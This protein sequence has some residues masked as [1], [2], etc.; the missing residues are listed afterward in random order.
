MNPLRRI[1]GGFRRFFGADIFISHSHEDAAEYAVA[2]AGRL[3]KRLAVYVDRYDSQPGK[4]ISERVVGH[5][6]SAS[7][8]VVIASPRSAA[9]PPVAEEVRRFAKLKRNILVVDIDGALGQCPW[10]DDVQGLSRPTDTEERRKAGRPDRT[11]VHSILASFR[12]VTRAQRLWRSAFAAMALVIV[13][14]IATVFFLREARRQQAIA[15]AQRIATTA[16]QAWTNQDAPLDSTLLL[17]A[18]SLRL[19]P[20]AEARRIVIEALPLRPSLQ[21]EADAALVPEATPIIHLSPDGRWVVG[22][23]GVLRRTSDGRRMWSGMVTGDPVFAPDGSAMAFWSSGEEAAAVEMVDLPQGSR[24]EWPYPDSPFMGLFV[25]ASDRYVR[26]ESS[27]ANV[28]LTEIRRRSDNALLASL[29][30][31]GAAAGTHKVALRVGNGTVE[32]RDLRDPEREGP[33]IELPGFIGELHVSADDRL[34][35]LG[36]WVGGMASSARGGLIA[37]FDLSASPPREIGARIALADPPDSLVVAGDGSE[38]VVASGTSFAGEGA[39]PTVTYCRREPDRGF[40]R[41][42][43]RRGDKPVG[44]TTAGVMFLDGRMLTIADRSTGARE[45]LRIVGVGTAVAAGETIVSFADG[46]LRSWRLV[47]PSPGRPGDRYL[48]A[49]GGYAVLPQGRPLTLRDLPGAHDLPLLVPA[50]RQRGNGGAGRGAPLSA[51]GS[52]AVWAE[53]FHVRAYDVRARQ[54]LPDRHGRPD[55]RITTALAISA[56]SRRIASAGADGVSLANPRIRV[57]DTR[58]GA[59]VDVFACAAKPWRMAMNSD[60]SQ[61]VFLD[62]KARLWRRDIPRR[63]TILLGTLPARDEAQ[64]Q[65]GALAFSRDDS[66]VIAA[67]ETVERW[68]V[69]DARR[70]WSASLGQVIAVAW[71]A[72]ENAIS[73][74]TG[75]SHVFILDART[76]ATTFDLRLPFRAADVSFLQTG[77][78]L[79]VLGADGEVRTISPDAEAVARQ[80]C[81][82]IG[83]PLTRNEWSR[84]IDTPYVDTCAR[85]SASQ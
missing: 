75:A 64:N 82:A 34:L 45:L 51:D 77:R 4:Q 26:I 78:D 24:R 31:G 53:P 56:D 25:A 35:V 41:L 5:L 67:R 48:D 39:I 66:S 30:A 32:V 55:D 29:Y 36:V 44:L 59:I 43:S 38:L 72:D 42:W 57:S 28:R 85:L 12:Y 46:R 80:V 13:S 49:G 8:L 33:R 7:M 63:Q 79:A 65:S 15:A 74:L 76:G 70:A 54:W 10:R 62:E 9:S 22:L 1:A 27:P 84:F 18:E 47:R 73:V 20:T 14:G 40:V 16:T 17:A 61:L 6:E 23:D 69:A 11:V 60:G 71:S 81:R 2:L 19:Y 37:A 21:W 58:S 83:R 52:I 50:G 68:S 3:S